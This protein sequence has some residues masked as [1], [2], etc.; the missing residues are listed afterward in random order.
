MAKSHVF[1]FLNLQRKCLLMVLQ[2][3]SFWM[4]TTVDD[5]N[6]T[7]GPSNEA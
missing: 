5:S 6:F 7:K 1:V 4:P 2:N 3:P